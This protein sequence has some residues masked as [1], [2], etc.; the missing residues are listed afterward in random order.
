VIPDPDAVQSPSTTGQPPPSLLTDL[1]AAT[2]AQTPAAIGR[3][4]GV[5][6]GL[7]IDDRHPH[8]PGRV[9]IRVEDGAQARELWMS[10]LT[11]SVIRRGDRVLLQQPANWPEP[12]VLGVLDGQQ[13]RSATAVT[14]GTLELQRDEQLT[15]QDHLGAP[16]LTIVP[17]P[18][19]PLLRLARADQSL[20]IDGR[21]RV[22]ADAID[23]R[24]RGHLTLGAGAD[25]VVT[26]EEIK[27][28]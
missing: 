19:G 12:V 26:G 10:G 9:L 8:L 24:A 11:H 27:L 2:V 22:V 1:I 14:A 28:N 6:V 20:E 13:A 15:I 5:V 7:C 16:L 4:A 23:M 17:T 21:L 3:H 18:Q 25:V